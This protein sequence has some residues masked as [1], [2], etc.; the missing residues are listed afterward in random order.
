MRGYNVL[1][2]MAF[3]YTGTS[4]LAMAKRLAENDEEVINDFVSTYKVPRVTLPRPMH[5]PPLQA[6][7]FAPPVS[8]AARR[9]QFNGGLLRILQKFLERR[10][11]FPYSDEEVALL[12]EAKYKMIEFGFDNATAFIAPPVNHE[13]LRLDK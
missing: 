5:D 6:V 3:Y 1:L 8:K 9:I 7:F 4:V 11:G 13:M 12:V 10:D 2:P